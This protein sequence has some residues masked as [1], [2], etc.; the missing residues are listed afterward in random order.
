MVN[1]TRH[2]KYFPCGNHKIH[3]IHELKTP[4][5]FCKAIETEYHTISQ[6]QFTAI[7]CGIFKKKWVTAIGNRIYE[8]VSYKCLAF[9][10]IATEQKRIDGRNLIFMNIQRVV[11]CCHTNAHHMNK[12]QRNNGKL[13]VNHSNAVCLRVCGAKNKRLALFH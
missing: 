8:W 13:F 12:I 11:L 1:S 2:T 7:C 5:L 10:F 6:F 9:Q 4:C 3:A